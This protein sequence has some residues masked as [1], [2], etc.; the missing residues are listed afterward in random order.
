MTPFVQ[1]V[2]YFLSLGTVACD[3]LAVVLIILLIAPARRSTHAAISRFIARYEIGLAF[4]IAAASVGGSLFYSEFAHF[5]PCELCW[6]QRG[7]LYTQAVIFFIAIVARKENWVRKFRAFVRKAGILLSAIG[8]PIAAYHVYLQFG[9]SALAPCSAIG[10]NCTYVYFVEF[11]YVTIPTMSL[12]AFVLILVL[13]LF[14][15]KS[16]DR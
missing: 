3:I 10:P 11:G 1:S 5:A 12:T 9:G 14:S 16:T 6:I 2:T 4:F 8:I 7:L 13:C 15:S